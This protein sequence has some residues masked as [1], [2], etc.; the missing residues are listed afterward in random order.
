MPPKSDPPTVTTARKRGRLN[1]TPA[2]ATGLEEV[3]VFGDPKRSNGKFRLENSMVHLT[4]ASQP[5]LEDL[6]SA[7]RDMVSVPV[8]D[9]SAVHETGKEGEHP[10][11]HVALRFARPVLST[12][13]RI[14]DYEGIHPHIRIVKNKHHFDYLCTTYHQKEGVPFSNYSPA[15]NAITLGDLGAC[16]TRREMV[17]LLDSRGE[18]E[19]AD[20]L[21]T[22]WKHSRPEPIPVTVITIPRPWQQWIFD[23]VDSDLP[24]DRT[25]I[26]VADSKGASG[27]TAASRHLFSERKACVLTGGRTADSLHALRPWMDSHGE[28]KVVIIDAARSTSLTNV[29][30]LIEM[31]KS[32]MFVSTKYESTHV[33]FENPP[34]VMVFSNQSPEI[35]KLSPDRWAICYPDPSG[36]R[37][38]YM[39]TGSS[40]DTAIEASRD[41]A[42]HRK[43]V[44]FSE[45]S[46]RQTLSVA[47]LD[48]CLPFLSL[49]EREKYWDRGM[50]PRIIIDG[51]VTGT[52]VR[53]EEHPLTEQEVERYRAT[54]EQKTLDEHKQ[55]IRRHVERII[56]DEPRIR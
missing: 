3:S 28:P 6:V 22:A 34:A 11:T 23:F 40:A 15:K 52:E 53:I 10:H 48:P 16:P 43:T 31:L 8:A 26:W 20:R 54:K 32:S 13:P 49:A 37:T 41:I 33:H 18:L 7:I 46:P 5:P 35:G 56:R 39:F 12:N 44:H 2:P 21:H 55:R 42:K 27:K 29:Y 30:E 17:E 1:V 51:K 50:F 9:F 47:S 36:Y 19:K 38:D 14:F 24:D 45:A 4:Y 25:V